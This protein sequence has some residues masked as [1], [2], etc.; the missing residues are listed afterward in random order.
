[1]SSLNEKKKNAK[2]RQI[3]VLTKSAEKHRAEA[4]KNLKDFF[5][6]DQEVTSR[7]Y[8]LEDPELDK[9][10]G[11]ILG[12]L[13]MAI[14][15]DRKTYKVPAL[16]EK[17]AD[18]LSEKILFAIERKSKM[19]VSEGRFFFD[20]GY[21]IDV[22]EDEFFGV[23][24]IVLL[25]NYMNKLDPN[26]FESRDNPTSS[27]DRRIA[28]IDK[29]TKKY[30]KIALKLCKTVN[31]RWHDTFNHQEK[32]PAFAKIAKEDVYRDSKIARELREK[33]LGV[34]R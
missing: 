24:R 23:N 4:K 14:S 18:I 5:M 19:E 21:T 31:N 15:A 1:M 33:A 10:T 28:K 17:K 30:S 11:R 27:N 25:S 8:L 34:N 12:G 13:A 22:K 9:V 16:N 29:I 6:K 26:V 32:M 7:D 2:S 3:E 20:A